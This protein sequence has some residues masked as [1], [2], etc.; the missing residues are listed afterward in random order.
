MD[1]KEVFASNLY[2][3]G[4]FYE[5]TKKPHAAQ[6][7][8]NRILAKY[9][10]TKVAMSATRRLENMNKKSTVHVSSEEGQ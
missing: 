3:T 10:E 9:P 2:D 8:Y 4:R 6:I 5:R 1:M 7:Y